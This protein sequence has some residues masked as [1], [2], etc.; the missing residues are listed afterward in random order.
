MGSLSGDGHHLNLEHKAGRLEVE[1][2]ISMVIV[3][4]LLNPGST[5]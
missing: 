1:D 5:M 4:A 2:T 3:E